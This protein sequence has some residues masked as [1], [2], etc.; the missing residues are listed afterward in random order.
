MSLYLCLY[1]VYDDIIDAE[2]WRNST[3]VNIA[4]SKIKGC[5]FRSSCKIIT[6]QYVYMWNNDN[7]NFT[8]VR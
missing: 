6:I 2:T 4:E 8:D 5:D 1:I 7:L 3:A